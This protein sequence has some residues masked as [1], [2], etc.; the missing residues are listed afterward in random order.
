MAVRS[1]AEVVSRVRTL[2]KCTAA[3]GLNLST[4][5]VQEVQK[6]QLERWK[7]LFKIYDDDG[8]GVLSFQEVRQLVR[9]DLKLKDSVV[10][11]WELRQLWKHIDLDNNDSV[12]LEEFLA[13][14]QGGKG[15]AEKTI[16]QAVFE[17]G[18]CLKQALR[19]S[20]ISPEKLERL[21]GDYEEADATKNCARADGH[22][23]AEEIRRFFREVLNVSKEECCDYYLVQVIHFLDRD[24]N[25]A[26]SSG[27]FLD[28][29]RYWAMAD[30]VEKSGRRNANAAAMAQIAARNAKQKRK[31]ETS[32]TAEKMK[33]SKH[34]QRL[35]EDERAVP[36]RDS[37]VSFVWMPGRTRQVANRHGQ[38]MLGRLHPF[39]PEEANIDIPSMLPQRP[40]TAPELS[41]VSPGQQ[42]GARRGSFI[43][44]LTGSQLEQLGEDTSSLARKGHSVDFGASKR[45]SSAPTGERQGARA[46]QKKPTWKYPHGYM[47]MKSD[48]LNRVETKLFEAGVDLRGSFHRHPSV[49]AVDE[50]LLPQTMGKVR[51]IHPIGAGNR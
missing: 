4:T 13:F 27:E 15:G 18:R 2:L 25:K 37:G 8:N 28:F 10:S 31:L 17:V 50:D 20:K 23:G 39:D 45:S 12:D 41:S 40:S 7:A 42:R 1:E 46:G 44:S 32:S 35:V 33:D 51:F 30:E 38:T 48:G 24:N 11:D 9:Q 21:F 49:A 16:P 14:V 29:V 19:K 36:Q 5:K 22:M 6:K 43:A 47:V 34:N 26:I 3:K